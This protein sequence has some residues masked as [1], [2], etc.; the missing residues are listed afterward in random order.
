[1]Q[2]GALLLTTILAGSSHTVGG[3]VL[4]TIAVDA[5]TGFL[6]HL[7]SSGRYLGLET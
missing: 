6:H 1:M 2:Q 3:D 4:G 5:N 7:K